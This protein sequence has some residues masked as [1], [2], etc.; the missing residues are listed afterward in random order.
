M[1][2]MMKGSKGS[3]DGEGNQKND[4]MPSYSKVQSS[5]HQS[6]LIR[7]LN[8]C[9]EDKSKKTVAVIVTFCSGGSYDS[10]FTSIQQKALDGT[11]V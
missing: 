9:E 7:I 2:N 8:D 1:G 5:K 10:L 6:N 3:K 11:K 4:D